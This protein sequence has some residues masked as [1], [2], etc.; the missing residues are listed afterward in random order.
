MVVCPDH[1]PRIVMIQPTIS[2][3][4]HVP[5]PPRPQGGRERYEWLGMN[6]DNYWRNTTTLFLGAWRRSECFQLKI[7]MTVLWESTPTTLQGGGA[8]GER[9]ELHDSH[10]RKQTHQIT[11]EEEDL[12]DLSN[13][14]SCC[15]KVT[16]TYQNASNCGTLYQHHTIGWGGRGG[17]GL[18]STA[19]YMGLYEDYYKEPL[20]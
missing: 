1:D 16:V 18:A 5:P 14:R 15:H 7:M 20:P 19:P 3:K 13:I 17:G 4:V 12:P 9:S 11:G 8:G 2:R 6:G 10:G